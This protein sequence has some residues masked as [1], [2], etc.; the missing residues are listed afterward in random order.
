MDAYTSKCC[1]RRGLWLAQPVTTRAAIARSQAVSRSTASASK[2]AS[3]AGTTA[4]ALTAKI[5]RCVQCWPSA[6]SFVPRPGVQKLWHHRKAWVLN[7][8]A[9]SASGHWFAS[10]FADC[11]YQLTWPLQ[12]DFLCILGCHSR[13]A[14]HPAWYVTYYRH[15]LL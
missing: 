11:L 9:F 3:T 12:Q 6:C 7:Q 2:L 10:Y 13:L 14:M 15:N 5:L 4:S 1:R 8:H